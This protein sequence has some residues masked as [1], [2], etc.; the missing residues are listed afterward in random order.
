M[1]GSDTN[2]MMNILIYLYNFGVEFGFKM[3]GSDTNVMMN[4][5]TYLYN[6]E[7]EFWFQNE[8][9]WY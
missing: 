6:F 9:L 5:L 1:S 4:T 3:S 8:R 7:V 2:V